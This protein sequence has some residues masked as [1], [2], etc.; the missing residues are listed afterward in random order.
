[1]SAIGP[2][3]DSATSTPGAASHPVLTSQTSVAP[4]LHRDILIQL[5]LCIT[6][7]VAGFYA[8]QPAA[9][10]Y[11]FSFCLAMFMIYHASQK[12]RFCAL[13]FFVASIPLMALLRGTFMPFNIPV[14]TLG[15]IFL[16]FF[17]S[18]GEVKE[19]WKR[20]D[21]MYLI[22]ATGVY[23][24]TSFWLTGDYARNLKTIEW[25]LTA[26][27]IV[28]LS[29]R[30]SY[31]YTALL[32]LGIS[33]I[34]MGVILLPYGD[35]LG[36]SGAVE[37][38]EWGIGNPIVLGVPTAF[39]MLLCIAERGRWVLL[40]KH[41]F[42]RM[43]L[44]SVCGLF[45]LLSTSRGSWAILLIGMGIV[46]AFDRQ[47]RK[48]M[49]LSVAAFSLI[50]TLVST[51]NLSSRMANV[52]HYLEKTFSPDT[53]IEKRTTGRIDQ[54]RAL[55]TILADSPLWGVGPGGGRAASVFYAKKN[56]IFH[57]LYLQIGAETGIFGLTLLSVL[58]VSVSRKAWKHFAVYGEIVP[59]LATI[60]FLLLGA[61][62]SGLEIVGGVV[63]GVGF[64]AGSRANLWIVRG[65]WLINNT[66]HPRAFQIVP[67]SGSL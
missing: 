1:M 42:W 12:D 31:L 63:L 14:A 38:L 17:V 25:S 33:A 43:I 27:A 26:S 64:V 21:L 46:A 57:A 56:I 11:S 18:R 50:L 44:V 65:R 40:D 58:I 5:G 16:W 66:D 52:N 2:L 35:R 10:G 60:S 54:W 15:A 53:S 62:V 13:T 24:L 22:G 61:S 30:R 20:R 51:L 19:F 36:M 3:P 7:L 67:A 8:K 45:L 41:P 48:P 29:E 49:L 37:G 23:W 55:P 4:K 59:L 28:V 34:T 47:A 6:P 32:G 9:G 39:F